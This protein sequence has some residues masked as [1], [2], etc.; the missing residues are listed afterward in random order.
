MTTFSPVIAAK[1]LWQMRIRK[2]PFVL[3]HAINSRCNMRCGFCEYW[4]ESGSQMDLEEVFRLLDE[5]RDFGILAYNA[6]TV[7]PLLREDLPEILAHAKGQG[8]RTYISMLCRGYGNDTDNVYIHK[9]KLRLTDAT[10]IISTAAI[11][12]FLVLM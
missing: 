6:W 5:A 4:K 12:V 2:R 9:N 1:A 10:F 11:L 8:E 3:S 7:E